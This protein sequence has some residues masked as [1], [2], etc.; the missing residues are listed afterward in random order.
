MGPLSHFHLDRMVEFASNRLRAES[1]RLA[2]ETTGGCMRDRRGICRIVHRMLRTKS[3][4]DS[5][6]DRS[7]MWTGVHSEYIVGKGPPVDILMATSDA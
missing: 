7:E 1:M 4:E 6:W 2:L 3:S 5:G